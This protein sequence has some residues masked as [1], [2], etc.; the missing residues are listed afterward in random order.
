MV[1]P[2]AQLDVVQQRARVYEAWGFV[3]EGARG[4]GISALFAGPNGTGKTLVADIIANEFQL[5]L[6]RIDLSGV[7]NKYIG[8]TEKNLERLFSVAECSC[9]P[10]V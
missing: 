7:V 1:L 3:E 6:Y 5:D 10:V 4:F 2:K 8:E 9:H